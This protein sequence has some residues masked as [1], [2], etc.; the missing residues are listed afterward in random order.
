MNKRD[1]E[2]RCQEILL[3]VKQNHAKGKN[4]HSLIPI[5]VPP[6]PLGPVSFT[7][8]DVQEQGVPFPGISL[9]LQQ[10][11]GQVHVFKGITATT[12]AS[13]VLPRPPCC[14]N[15]GQHHPKAFGLV[16][17][18]VGICGHLVQ[19]EYFHSCSKVFGRCGQAL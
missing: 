6:E 4:G 12:K 5:L 10:G 7:P 14:W 3:Q 19:S 13:P 8:R 9:G 2:G 17:D 11:G 18:A 16:D 1:A 15:E